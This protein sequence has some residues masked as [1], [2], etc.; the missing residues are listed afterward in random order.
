VKNIDITYTN[1]RESLAAPLNQP[2]S[3]TLSH[4]YWIERNASRLFPQITV[5]SLRNADGGLSQR[6]QTEY[7]DLGALHIKEVTFIE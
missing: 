2:N 7:V 1:R 6:A 3:Q 5:Q 4:G